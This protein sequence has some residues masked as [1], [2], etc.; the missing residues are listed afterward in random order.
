MSGCVSWWRFWTQLRHNGTRTALTNT[1]YT[2][3]DWA[4]G[5]NLYFWKILYAQQKIDTSSIHNMKITRLSPQLTGSRL[6]MMAIWRALVWSKPLFFFVELVLWLCLMMIYKDIYIYIHQVAHIQVITAIR[7]RKM[8]VRTRLIHKQ[9]YIDTKLL[10]T[11][12]DACVARRRYRIDE[13]DP[14]FCA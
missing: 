1:V 8:L 2:L 5:L 6:A 7:R 10:Y 13:A 14:L 9:L 4:N 12:Y 3:F 11:Y